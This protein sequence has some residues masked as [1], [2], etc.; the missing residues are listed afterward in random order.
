M[1]NKTKYGKC[2][3]C[4]IESYLSFE[5]I[6]PKSAFNNH[7]VF[8]QLFDHLVN[9]ESEHFGRRMKSNRGYGAY[10]LCQPCNN[11][12]GGWYAK[13]FSEFAQQ[14]MEIIG[15]HTKGTR[16]IEGTYIIKPLNVLKQVLVMFMSADKADVLLS[17]KELRNF[18]LNTD[19]Q[20]LPNR[21]KIFLYSNLS[22]RYRMMG[23]CVSTDNKL[24]IQRWAEINFKP[25]GYLLADNSD[26]AQENMLD[27][28]NFC[29]YQYNEQVK[30]SL[31]TPY[32]EINSSPFIGTYYVPR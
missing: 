29:N 7:P 1:S 18:L 6:P 10:T 3:L 22:N 12:T 27:I 21:W 19:Y 31:R 23:Y 24:K 26:P 14:G 15:N 20:I 11:N 16:F 32:L 5:H 2:R 9:Q 8:I 30:I 4:G 25:F 28:T 17:D 13:N